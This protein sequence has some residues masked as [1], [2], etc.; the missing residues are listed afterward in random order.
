LIAWEVSLAASCEKKC[1][2]RLQIYEIRE[3]VKR[4]FKEA[5]GFFSELRPKTPAVEGITT[6]KQYQSM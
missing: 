6:L 2:C 1:V 4:M 5:L 3:S